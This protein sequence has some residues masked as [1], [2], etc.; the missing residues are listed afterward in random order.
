[1]GEFNISLGQ[2]IGQKATQGDNKTPKGM[3]FVI[4]KHRGKFDGAY[5]A[6]YGGHWIKVNYPNKYDAARGVAAGIVTPRQES[7]IA[8]SWARRSPTL[9]NTRLG[10]G[11]GFHGW[12]QEW[13]NE[14]PRRLSWGCVV[15][16]LF[17]IR[18]VFDQIPQGTMVV[19]F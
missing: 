2:G 16:H 5:G 18:T 6:Y 11:I 1:L 7:E 4:G 13:A 15:M 8:A 12:A 17:D 10:G 14:G 3:Y 9:E 19:I